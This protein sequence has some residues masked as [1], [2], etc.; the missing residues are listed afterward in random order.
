[1]TSI[2]KF[3][4]NKDD[5]RAQ[6]LRKF[7]VFKIIPIINVDGV[8]RGYYRFDTNSYNLNRHYANPS[9]KIT[10]EI[11]AIKRL[12]LFYSQEKRIR[13]YLDL[14][15]HVQSKGVF[16]FGNCL[17]YL[18]QVENSLFPKVIEANLE[19]LQLDNCNFNEKS[20]KSRVSFLLLLRK[21]E[22]CSQKKVLEELIY[23]NVLV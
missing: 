14:H 18:M 22:I 12:F 3:L 21:K 2:I 10:P 17:D 16:L 7:F 4:T 23:I 20:M 9:I 5:V 1:M 15:A 8:Y 13:Y 11:Y 19:T 6:I